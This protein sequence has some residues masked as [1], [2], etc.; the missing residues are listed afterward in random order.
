MLTTSIS[1]PRQF[2]PLWRR[3]HRRMMK[4][5]IQALR[6]EVQKGKVRRGVKRQYN[7]EQG[8]YAIVTTRFTESEYDAL[9]FIAATARVSV[10]LLIFRLIKFWLTPEGQTTKMFVTNYQINNVLWT[11]DRAIITE[12]LSFHDK[13]PPDTETKTIP[14]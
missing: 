10:S 2:A 8:E 14:T 11:E 7:G 3:Q 9:H 5:G 1:I 13:S 4:T 12:S 6:L